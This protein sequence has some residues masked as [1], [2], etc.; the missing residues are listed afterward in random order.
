MEASEFNLWRLMTY[1]L[2]YSRD[3]RPM[4]LL[5]NHEFLLETL[6][7]TVNHSQRH[8]QRSHVSTGVGQRSPAGIFSAQRGVPELGVTLLVTLSGIPKLSSWQHTLRGNL[9]DI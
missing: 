6:L 8:P 1:R 4:F 2:G 3:F 5:K 9:V 7:K